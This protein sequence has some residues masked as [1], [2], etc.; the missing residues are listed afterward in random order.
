MALVPSNPYGAEWGALLR[1]HRSTLRIPI[2]HPSEGAAYRMSTRQGHEM[3]RNRISWSRNKVVH[4]EEDASE[5]FDSLETSDIWWWLL[6]LL[7]DSASFASA[8]VCYQDVPIPEE[9]LHA[10]AVGPSL[11]QYSRGGG[12]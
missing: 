9:G 2:Q 10:V 7:R 12:P 1:V 11:L 3:R 5:A 4:E 6:L 8:T